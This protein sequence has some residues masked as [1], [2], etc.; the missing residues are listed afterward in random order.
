MY[1]SLA[2]N[3]FLITIVTNSHFEPGTYKNKSIT[4]IRAFQDLSLNTTTGKEYGDIGYLTNSSNIQL[5]SSM[6]EGLNASA[7]RYEDLT[8]LECTKVY[9]NDFLSNRRNLFLITSSKTSKNVTILDM[10]R[11]RSNVTSLSNWMCPGKFNSDRTTT[12]RCNT[13]VPAVNLRRG[14]TWQVGGVEITGCKSEITDEKCKVRF[15]L[16]MGT[17][18][19]E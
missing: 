13:N 8:P 16:V 17:I 11:V 14:D 4:D 6:L 2:A 19:I 3:D 10:V 18:M 7:Q 12:R 1:T 15:S 5:F 9:N